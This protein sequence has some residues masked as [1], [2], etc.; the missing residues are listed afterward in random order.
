MLSLRKRVLLSLVVIVG[1]GCLGIGSVSAQAKAKPGFPQKTI[2]YHISSTGSYYQSVW[3]KAV[4]NWN[5]LKV[6]KLVKTSRASEAEL[7]LT[8]TKSAG[9]KSPYTYGR[10]YFITEEKDG[11]VSQTQDIGYPLEL[12]RKL[13]KDMYFDKAERSGWAGMAIGD[14]LGLN[15]TNHYDSIMNN[16][17]FKADKPTK[18]D[19]KNLK[20]LYKNIPF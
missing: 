1:L 8:T 3:R 14:A 18:Y 10:S 17:T 11:T 5:N 19:K 2:S 12:S 9:K 15:W 6:V 13:M 20:K 4:K 7:V 16:T